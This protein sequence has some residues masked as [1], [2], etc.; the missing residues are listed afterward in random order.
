[1]KR[2]AGAQRRGNLFL[3]IKFLDT[4]SRIEFL[5]ET[6]PYKGGFEFVENAGFDVIKKF[7]L[8]SVIGL[9]LEQ[10]TPEKNLAFP[11][12]LFEYMKFGFAIV[13]SDAEM[14]KKIIQSSG[15]G[16][17][18][19]ADR[20]EEFMDAIDLLMSNEDLL[21]GYSRKSLQASTEEYSWENEK[22]KLV[23]MIE[24]LLVNQR[25]VNSER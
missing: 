3:A 7:A 20:P 6:I 16:I 5:H 25:S 11:A 4:Q 17:L 15:A 22:I 12:K 14:N 1:V 8:Q 9:A 10:S 23:K 21:K 13:S 24:D 18:C 2:Y 19:T